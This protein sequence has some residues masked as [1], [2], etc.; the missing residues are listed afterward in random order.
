MKKK[1]KNKNIKLLFNNWETHKPGSVNYKKLISHIEN[2]YFK[3]SIFTGTCLTID[4][5]FSNFDQIYFND[6][7]KNKKILF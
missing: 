6:L 3:N 5:S 1:F 4:N 2:I 7:K